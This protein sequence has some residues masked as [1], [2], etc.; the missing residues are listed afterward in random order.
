MKRLIDYHLRK[1]KESP[2]RQPLLL[3]DAR[4]VGKTYAVREIGKTFSSF[5]E[6]NFEFNKHLPYC[7][8]S[9]TC[10]S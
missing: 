7:V 1:L 8:H 3:R 5:V 2:L 4:Q 9:S 10:Y 6:I